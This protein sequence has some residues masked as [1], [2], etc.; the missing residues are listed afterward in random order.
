MTGEAFDKSARLLGL[1]ANPSGGAALEAFAA[2]GDPRRFE[3]TPPLRGK[4]G[5]NFSYAGLKT[6]V[7]LAIEAEAPGPPT[8]A[9]WQVGLIGYPLESVQ[10]C[11]A[12]HPVQN[13]SWNPKRSW[14]RTG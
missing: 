6:G 13:Q 7:R 8:D 9:N 11:K 12:L 5:C 3:F 1:P 2:F 10:G 4:P 14:V